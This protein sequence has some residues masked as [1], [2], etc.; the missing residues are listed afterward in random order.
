M[1]DLKEFEGCFI[2]KESAGAHK[3]SRT[4]KFFGQLTV[5]ASAAGSYSKQITENYIPRLELQDQ[6]QGSSH[7]QGQD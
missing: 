1:I 2:Y 4:F 3:T 5:E 7:I 6:Q